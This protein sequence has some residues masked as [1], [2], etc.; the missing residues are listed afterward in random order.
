MSRAASGD[1]LMSRELALREALYEGISSQQK[2]SDTVF[3]DGMKVLLKI[4]RYRI[5]TLIRSVQS[6]GT[7]ACQHLPAI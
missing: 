4:M 3:C 5:F 6:N 1:P 2:N 7:Y